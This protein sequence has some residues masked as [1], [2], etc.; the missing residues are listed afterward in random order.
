LLK[1]ANTLAE[2]TWQL[3]LAYKNAVPSLWLITLSLAASPVVGDM[4]GFLTAQPEIDVR[5][6]SAAQKKNSFFLIFFTPKIPRG[7]LL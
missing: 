4:Y 3:V 5:T 6:L 2:P 1:A 7:N